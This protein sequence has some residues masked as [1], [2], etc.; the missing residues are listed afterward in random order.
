MLLLS[1]LLHIGVDHVSG[2]VIRVRILTF[3]LL[4]LS[5]VVI[6]EAVSLCFGDDCVKRGED[7]CK[8]VYIAHPNIMNI[9]L[10][11]RLN[12]WNTYIE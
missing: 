10:T 6:N 11:I 2:E 1:I 4:L 3:L 7:W 12:K 9:E 8:S 5:A